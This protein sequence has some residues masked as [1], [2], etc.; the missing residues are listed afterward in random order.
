M[1][2]IPCHVH[3]T[4][5]LRYG[6]NFVV[7]YFMVHPIT[8]TRR[9]RP[10][11]SMKIS[12]YQYSKYHCG[13]KTVVRP[14]YLHNGISYTGKMSSLYWIGAQIYA[15]CECKFESVFYLCHGF[16]VSTIYYQWLS[17]CRWHFQITFIVWWLKYFD[18]QFIEI[19]CQV[20]N[21]H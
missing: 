10:W 1:D 11:F 3:G 6:Y 7:F 2:G 13:D 14:S 12:S 20:S 15:L 4:W 17:F 21:E 16:A 18:S 19:C 5:C 8:H 9:P